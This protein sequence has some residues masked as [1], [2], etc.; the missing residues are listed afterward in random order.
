MYTLVAQ[1]EWP[2]LERRI[3]LEQSPE[4]YATQL[5]K[6]R[7]ASKSLLPEKSE[8]RSSYQITVTETIENGE[9]QNSALK[10]TLS[11]FGRIARS[12]NDC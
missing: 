2:D 8:P 3:E 5:T 6:R 4:R 11:I 12:A 7:F 9:C 1:K 10:R